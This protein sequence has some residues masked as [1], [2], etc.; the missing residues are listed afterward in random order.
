MI[1]LR[2]KEKDSRMKDR[3]ERLKKKRGR[4]WDK[5]KSPDFKFLDSGKY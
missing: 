2:V 1:L 4:G 5:T 3:P